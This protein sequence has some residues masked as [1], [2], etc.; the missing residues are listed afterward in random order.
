MNVEDLTND[1]RYFLSYD[2]FQIHELMLRDRT[3]VAAYHDAIMNNKNLFENKVKRISS[4]R[5][6]SNDLLLGRFGR[7]IGNGNFEYVRSK[8]RCTS[9]LCC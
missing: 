6:K 2:Q 3:R 8:S 9:R 4:N 5:S 7:R 1:Q